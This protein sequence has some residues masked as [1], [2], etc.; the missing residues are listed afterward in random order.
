VPLTDTVNPPR[1][2]PAGI[3]TTS[4]APAASTAACTPATDP[5]ATR[6]RPPHTGTDDTP[7]TRADTFDHP[8]TST[9]TTDATAGAGAGADVDGALVDGA[10]VG[11][12]LVGGAE[13]DG[14]LVGGALVGGDGDA[15]DAGA[16][17]AG[18]GG[19]GVG[20]AGVATVVALVAG[21]G[22]TA[23]EEATAGEGIGG[24][25]A[26]ASA[27]GVAGD[28]TV[29]GEEEV[30]GAAPTAG[31]CANPVTSGSAESP[32]G[33]ASAGPPD[34]AP[35]GEEELAG[36]VDAP[37]FEAAPPVAAAGSGAPGP[38]AP[39]PTSPEAGEGITAATGRPSVAAARR[40]VGG[41]T[42]VAT[43]AI[44]PVTSAAPTTPRHPAAPRRTVI[45]RTVPTGALSLQRCAGCSP[46]RRHRPAARPRGGGVRPP[47]VHPWGTWRRSR[48]PLR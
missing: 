10:L 43:E 12:A 1:Y 17:G 20:G 31:T 11:G 22:V 29:P 47:G 7:T 25:G 48:R 2:D 24:G 23:G 44:A 19:A 5:T 30:V 38:S 28:R 14:A 33:L 45:A 34:A 37:V 27:G 3:T 39:V 16:V 4:P 35:V 21:E 32:G 8:T 46:R 42:P 36:G 6:V 9:P 13:V 40:G 41:R 18:V 15:A 26:A